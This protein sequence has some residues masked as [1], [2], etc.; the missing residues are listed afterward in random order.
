MDGV[1][2][3]IVVRTEV[4]VAVHDNVYN[5]TMSHRRLNFACFIFPCLF[6]IVNS[7]THSNVSG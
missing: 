6:L 1:W 2:I 4:R 7:V 5:V 3:S